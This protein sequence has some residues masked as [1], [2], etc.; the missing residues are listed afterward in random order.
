MFEIAVALWF[1]FMA[2][3]LFMIL[4]FPI[5]FLIRKH[6]VYLAKRI[7]VSAVVTGHWEDNSN[8]EGRCY[9]PPIVRFE[10]DG[11]LYELGASVRG[12]QR[13]FRNIFP[14]GQTVDVSFIEEPTRIGGHLVR[15]E[16]KQKRVSD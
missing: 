4:V 14:V 16:S 13:D 10:H 1:A 2:F 11:V 9:Y 3:L 12:I 6:R 7:F 8:S 5:L 15:I